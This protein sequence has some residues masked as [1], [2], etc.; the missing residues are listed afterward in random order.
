MTFGGQHLQRGRVTKGLAK[1]A[2]NGALGREVELLEE[3]W[4]NGNAAGGPDLLQ[5]VVRVDVVVEV[6]VMGVYKSQK[7]KL[8]LVEVAGSLKPC[9]PPK[10]FSS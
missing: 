7:G 6:F 9:T 5:G 4:G 1:V 3:L 8:A 2:V 10:S